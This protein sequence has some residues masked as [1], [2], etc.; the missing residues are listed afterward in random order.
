MKHSRLLG[1]GS[2][3]GGIAWLIGFLVDYVPA[4]FVA[5]LFVNWANIRPHADEMVI[6]KRWIDR[7][8]KL[9]AVYLVLAFVAMM[10]GAVP[11]GSS[12]V[13]QALGIMVTVAKALIVWG[14]AYGLFRELPAL[15]QRAR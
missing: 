4:W 5:R 1:T 8:I 13:I 3:Q 12:R 15:T 7:G 9:W 6:C 11:Y 14:L 2:W 10:M